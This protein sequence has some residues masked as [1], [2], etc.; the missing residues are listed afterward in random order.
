MLI[1]V[2]FPGGLR[3]DA[4]IAGHTV[5]T[6]QREKHG[7][8]GTASPPFDLFLASIATCMGL[9]ALRFC[10]Q[11]DIDT[12]DLQLTLETEKDPESGMIS[13]IRSR[14]QLPSD[15][16]AKYVPA[17]ERAMDQC[18]VK[19]HMMNPPQFETRSEIAG[20]S[21]ESTA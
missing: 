20:S 15:F 3:V 19:K 12:E 8:T 4:R 5:R 13:K 10:Q 2:Q 7:G 14:L 9:Y 11:R 18:A 17:I 1:E 21:A 16:P 6:D